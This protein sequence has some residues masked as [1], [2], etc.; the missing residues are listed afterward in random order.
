MASWNG[1]VIDLKYTDGICS[2]DIK[3]KIKRFEKK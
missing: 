3:L 1:K 2:T